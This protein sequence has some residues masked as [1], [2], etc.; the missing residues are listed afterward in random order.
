MQKVMQKV[1]I[2]QVKVDITQ[3]K[4]DITQ[5]KVDITQVKVDS[6]QVDSTQVS[7][8]SLH[9][10]ATLGCEGPR[11]RFVQPGRG[12]GLN[13]SFRHKA[14]F[15]FM[16]VRSRLCRALSSLGGYAHAVQHFRVQLS[17]ALTSY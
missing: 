15:F 13:A 2:T 6:T 4:V 16:K 8:T 1:D 10:R 17:G 7:H 12:S 3:V 9:D 5:E 14:Q 11:E